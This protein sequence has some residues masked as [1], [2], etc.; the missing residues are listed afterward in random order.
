MLPFLKKLHDFYYSI[1][2]SLNV[3]YLGITIN[4]TNQNLRANARVYISLGT[5][6]HYKSY[7]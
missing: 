6:R 7:Q 4:F 1:L 5:I 2:N 3:K